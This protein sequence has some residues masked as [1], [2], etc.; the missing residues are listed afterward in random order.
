MP[1]TARIVPEQGVLHII[2]RGN[3]RQIVF[4]DDGD[5]Q[6]YRWLLKL[7]QEEH[8]FKLYH[9]CL[10]SN[11]VH[12]IIETTQQTNLSKL[13]K[14]IN[15]SYMHHF[16]RKYKYVGHFW[17]DRYKSLLIE[18]DRY[19]LACG[20][21]VELNPVRAK[22]VTTPDKYSWNSYGVY[23]GKKE[24]DLVTFDP[25][26]ESLG[27]TQKERSEEYEKLTCDNLNLNNR[28]IGSE[29]FVRDME[30]RFGLPNIARKKGRPF[31]TENK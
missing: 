27:K 17:Q 22:I 19:L 25:V 1:R 21:Y 20:K 12:L 31:K 3:N 26:Y 7:Y 5:F 30:Q 16:R 6:K 10:M 23:T 13:M 8:R 28:Y 9:Y 2:T 11:H 4:R 15:L 18:K 14:Q 24:D 29:A